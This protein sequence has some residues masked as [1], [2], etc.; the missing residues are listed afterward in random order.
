MH[1]QQSLVNEQ[2]KISFT[3]LGLILIAHPAAAAQRQM[4]ISAA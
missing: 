4:Q 1:E 3:F 2:I